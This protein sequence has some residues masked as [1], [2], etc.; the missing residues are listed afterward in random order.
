MPQEVFKRTEK[1]YMLTKHTYD[2]LISE[3]EKYM[4]KDRYFD[5]HIM[6]LYYDTPDHRLI[7]ASMEKPVFKEKVRLRSYGV[8]DS[9]SEVFLEYKRKFKG[10]VYKRRSEMTLEN[11]R[12][13]TM[14]GDLPLQSSRNPQIENE[15]RYAFKLYPDLAP[16][17]LI[18]YHRHAYDGKENPDLRI[19]FDGQITYRG[20][21]LD[22]SLG[23]Y[24]SALLPPDVRLMEIKIPGA[25][26]LWLSRILCRLEIYPTS[27]SK[28]GRAYTELMLGGK[29]HGGDRP[30]QAQID[31]AV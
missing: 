12:I 8:P 21:D 16:R 4:T 14:G 9:G 20:Y 2:K 23:V 15:L 17:M 25:M 27:F 30:K 22:L 28:Y 10:V 7:R 6:S 1:K 5:T 29:L 26:P 19:T 24:G 18:S 11:A 13:F 3:L 31:I